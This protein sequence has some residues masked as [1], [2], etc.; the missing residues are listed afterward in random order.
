MG[1]FQDTRCNSATASFKSPPRKTLSPLLCVTSVCVYLPPRPRR[2][3]LTACGFVRRNPNRRILTHT[4][5]HSHTRVHTRSIGVQSGKG[6]SV[7]LCEWPLLKQINRR[8]HVPQPSKRKQLKAIDPV[9]GFPMNMHVS[10]TF[11]WRGE[12]TDK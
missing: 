10:L 4:H 5:A 3:F 11:P 9:P 7:V 6:L 12:E 1:L 2:P 8:W